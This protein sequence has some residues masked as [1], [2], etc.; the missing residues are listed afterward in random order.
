MNHWLPA[1]YDLFGHERS[2][3]AGNAYRWGLK[4]RFN[5][6]DAEQ[7]DDPEQVNQ[8]A[9]ES[10]YKEVQGLIQLLNRDVA[11][12]NPVLYVPDV[13]F[14]RNIGE[15]AGQRHSVKGELLDEE[16]YSRHLK[17]V[18]PTHEDRKKLREITKEP[19]WIA[20]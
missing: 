11:D 5:E 9:R 14:H 8:A 1:S 4:G 16:A 7:M 17:E 13:K 2:K 12:G 10:Y 3:G 20:P 19:D 15:F 6:R 18:L